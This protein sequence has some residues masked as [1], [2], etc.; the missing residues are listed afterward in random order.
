MKRL[1]LILALLLLT[2]LCYG[3][4][5]TANG[6]AH[7]VSLTWTASPD[8][9]TV[10]VYRASGACTATFSPLTTNQAS[11]GPYTDSTASVGTF[12]YQ[13]TAVV[14]GAESAPSNCV[15]VT[16]SPQPPTGLTAASH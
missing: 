10:N 3:L 14:G 7:T 8:G 5:V 13:I 11:A 2:P 4:G 12:S 6:A 1:P 16:I 9:G 15:T